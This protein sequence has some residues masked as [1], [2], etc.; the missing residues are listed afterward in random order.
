MPPKRRYNKSGRKLYNKYGAK[1]VVTPAA[2]T[3][4]AAVRRA[5]A[6]SV[7][8]NIETKTATISF[9]DGVEIFHNNFV[10]T[11]TALLATTQGTTDPT[12]G[13]ANCRIGDQINI[14]KIQLKFMLELNE[15]FSDVTFRIMVIKSAR[16]DVPTRANMFNNLSGNKM[17]DV[18]NKERFTII[19]QKWV[20]L[21]APG[22]TGYGAPLAAFEGNNAGMVGT[23][24]TLVSSRATKI[25][26]LSIPG[27]KFGK[28]GIVTYENGTSSVKFFD[29][30]VLV[31][32]YS[33]FSTSQ[34]VYYVGRIND[35]IKIMSFQD[36]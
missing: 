32:A 26:S 3:L 17:L 8:R 12:I 7:A 10:Q 1:T 23:A 16:G 9:T 13:V 21:K 33:N 24:G 5:V 30:Q 27:S 11:D 6:Q 31:Y 19:K 35:Y 2:K 20:K 28:N 15:R 14:K 4:Q 34:D 36:A 29:Y 22:L 18:F 25:V